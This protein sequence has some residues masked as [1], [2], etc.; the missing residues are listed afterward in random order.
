MA[1]ATAEGSGQPER[2]RGLLGWIEWIGN[3]LPDPTALFVVG[4]ALVMLISALAAWQDWTVRPLVAAPVVDEA[5]NTV[6]DP[7]TN[8]PKLEFVEQT[9]ASGAPV[10]I[11]ARN[12]VSSDGLFWALD[13]MVT[14]F[15]N[16]PPLGVVLVGMIGIGVAERTGLFS[17]LLRA[18]MLVVP[19]WAFTP[20]MV[21]LGIMS[22]LGLDAGYV[23]LP[24]LAGALY[25]SVGR[26]P[27]VGIAAVLAGV[28]AGF[29][30]NLLVTGLDPLLAGLSTAGAQVVDPDYEVAPPCNWWFMIA[31][32]FVMTGTGWFVTARFVEPRLSRRTPEE[33][34]PVSPGGSAEEIDSQRLDARERRGLLIAVTAMAVVVAIVVALVL[35]PGSPLYGKSPR[36]AVFDRWVAV[37]VPIIFFMFLLPG[38]LYGVAMGNIRS[39]KDAT[40]AMVESIA[41]I[42]PIIVLAFFAAQFI[43]YLDHSQLG[44]MLAF[45][46]GSALAQAQ[47]PPWALL[48]SFILLIAFFN[49][50]IGSM[51]AKYAIVAPIFVPM[52]M[53]VGISPELT[54]ASYRIGD[55]ATNVITPLNAYLVIILMFMQRYAK[56]AGMG[57]LVSMMLPYSIIFLVVWTLLL[58]A[59]VGLGIPL[60]VNGP[61]TYPA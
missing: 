42:A 4:A 39:S 35:I 59:W 51:S 43:A 26:S 18:F 23:V 5:G 2:P 37:I 50:F 27:L 17:A 58:L 57:T 14:N 53:I 9:D 46:G 1:E 7:E 20:A 32:T 52:L 55:S 61:L 38:L 11:R 15:I 19:A 16:F 13:T 29:N 22:S 54:Q 49:L 41:A 31:S 10:E 34:G 8:Q 45:A 36:Q 25:A 6:I 30:A 48:V 21:F 24:P 60:G 3:A 56:G 12:L 40:T 44:R 33:G 47:L 28:A